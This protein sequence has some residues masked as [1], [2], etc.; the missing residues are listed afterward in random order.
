M[1]LACLAP[2]D[3][4]DL[5][6]TDAGRLDHPAT[7]LSKVATGLY[8]RAEVAAA[9]GPHPPPGPLYTPDEAVRLA[10]KVSDSG[11]ANHAGVRVPVRSH[12]NLRA[13]D[14]T[15]SAYKD[16]WPL[17]GAT[18]GWPLGRD[19][20]IHLSGTTWPNHSSAVRDMA[21]VQEYLWA[22]V[23][24]G[25]LFP[26]GLAPAALN[27]RGTATIPLLTVPKPP[28]PVK[29]RVCGDMSFPAGASVNDAIPEGS[30]GGEAY[31]VKLPTIWDFLALLREVGID[32]AL[33][34]K[35]D[36]S[37]GYRQL[38]VCPGDWQAQLFFVPGAGYMMDTRAIFGGRPCGLFMQ[39]TNQ[40]LAWAAVNTSISVDEDL[41][42]KSSNPA[43]AAWRGISPYIDD[44][45]V[46]A[47]A[48]C[49]DATWRNLLSV[50]EATNVKLSTTPGHVSPPGR[51][52]RAL[53]FDVDCDTGFMSIPRAKLNEM[54][55]FAAALL[56]KGSA[57]YLQ[58]KQLLG[59]VCRCIMVI[60]EGRPF[61]GRLLT[62]LHGPQRAQHERVRLPAGALADLQW[63][64]QHGPRLNTKALINPPASTVISAI[65]VDGRGM[66]AGGGRPSLGGICYTTREFFAMEAP[67]DF[68]QAPVHV[69]EA[70][71][72]LAAARAWVPAM[73]AHSEV[74]VGSDNQPVVNAFL[75]GRAVD[76]SLAA[77]T[78]LLWGVFATST[79]SFRLR[80]VPTK[81][82]SA[83]GVSRL[84]S[85]HID[86]LSKGGWRRLFLPS[87]F[88]ALNE[89]DVFRHQA[90]EPST[91]RPPHA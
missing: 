79:C 40:A 5:S 73:P 39:R 12:L 19:P 88:F 74:G 8:S 27:P 30:Y 43:R 1:L 81:A 34:A 26:L 7:T 35:A 86:S 72:L 70:I 38:P 48:A 20:A 80:Y 58:L 71:A 83:D 75:H 32:D 6:P 54:L 9:A 50:Y 24:H 14:F 59:R 57:T 61:I 17:R 64:V 22:E 31:R 91:W 52:V 41:A 53:G 15:L 66:Q 65:L 18:F 62:L 90:E 84:D 3:L 10:T 4:A 67:P 33:V 21:Q 45:L 23:R 78:R 77:M 28:D 56:A 2:V 69:I 89:S 44:A 55:Q 51:R 42:G 87:S 13:L 29:V 36:L 49:A 76:P 63:W 11:R 60:R 85:R 47:H 46:V 37:R 25:A 16:P 68:H 82:N